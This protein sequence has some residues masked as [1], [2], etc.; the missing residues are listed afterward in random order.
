MIGHCLL[1]G[2]TCMILDIAL[3]M[4]S[5]WYYCSYSYTISFLAL[6]GI[7]VLVYI[8]CLLASHHISIGLSMKYDNDQSTKGDGKGEIA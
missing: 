5:L 3:A 8:P 6:N 1:V 7:L 4:M 2:L